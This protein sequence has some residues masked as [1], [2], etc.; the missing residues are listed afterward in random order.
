MR[1]RVLLV[2]V[3]FSAAA[4][5][6]ESAP[7]RPSAAPA[8]LQMITVPGRPG[9]S[10]VVLVDAKNVPLFRRCTHGRVWTT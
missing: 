2:L 9:E 3:L 6:Q 8:T 4:K 10:C 7:R 5:P 1:Y